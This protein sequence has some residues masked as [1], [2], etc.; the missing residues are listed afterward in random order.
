[1]TSMD[2]L[3]ATLDDAYGSLMPDHQYC[4]ALPNFVVIAKI[5]PLL[6]APNRP[7]NDCDV[8]SSECLDVLFKLRSLSSEWKWLVETSAEWAAFRLAKI[9][10]RGLVMRGTSEGF[11]LRC[12]LEEFNNVFTLLTTPACL[13]VP[14]GH[15]PLIAPFPDIDDR[16]LLVLK[17]ALEMSRDVPL[18]PDASCNAQ[19]YIP[20]ELGAIVSR[21][22]IGVGNRLRNIPSPL[23]PE[24]GMCTDAGM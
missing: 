23:S 5:W 17:S 15:H 6:M 1:M 2:V 12:A 20:P 4:S 16:W 9:H 7:T 3:N 13:S 11:A 18:R 24:S 19:M 8:P 10:S 14:I 21:E 22:R